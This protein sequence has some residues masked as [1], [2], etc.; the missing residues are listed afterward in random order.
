MAMHS[1]I[2]AW[3]I[4]WTGY[5]GGLQSR[6]SQGVRHDCGSKAMGGWVMVQR[7]KR[8]LKVLLPIIRSD[9]CITF[10]FPLLA[11]EVA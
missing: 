6:G 2:L 7:L 5:A 1:H 11:A 3:R 4:S 9:G 8:V 10:Y